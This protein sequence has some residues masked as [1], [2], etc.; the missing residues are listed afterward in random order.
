MDATL[1]YLPSPSSGVWQL[2]PFPVRAY[3]LAI[4]TGVVVAV[5]MAER[6]WVARGGTKG[7]P[8]DIATIAVPGGIIGARIYHVITSPAAYL[9]D[10]ISA[11]YVWQGG[12][13]IPGG[14]AGGFLAGYIVCKRR[15]VAVGAFADAIA[16]GVALAQAI[17]RLGNWFNQ[18]LFGRPTMLPWGLTIDPDN[19]DAVPGA[20]AYHPTFLYELLWNVGVAGLVLWADRRFKL[21]HGRAFALYLAAYATGRLW[22]E[23]LRIDQANSFFGVRLN[24]FVMSVVLLGALAYLI[25][26]RRA[27]RETQV[28]RPA[29]PDV[30]PEADV[31]ADSE[32]TAPQEVPQ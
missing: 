29:A 1:A 24:V 21:G 27:T 30:E 10:P 14:V 22:I 3:A 32:T 4:I 7:V 9:D 6:R 17:G 25:V 23:T 2:G 26:R 13:G 5:V 20:E 19:P 8:T 11:L 12:L 18:E 31:A 16:P 28:E 15:G